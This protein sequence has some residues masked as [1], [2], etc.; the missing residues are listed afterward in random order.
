MNSKPLSYLA[1][2]YSAF[3]GGIEV[4]F[5]AACELTAR[6][7]QSGVH[8]YSPIAHTHPVALHG[9]LDPLDLEV[10]LPFDEV[11]LWRCDMLIVAHLPTW[12]TSKGVAHEIAFFVRADKPIFDLDVDTLTMIARPRRISMAR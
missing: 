1:T 9:R 5:R 6:L 3:P 2:P 7:L 12:D 4:G 10:W 8:C 11:M